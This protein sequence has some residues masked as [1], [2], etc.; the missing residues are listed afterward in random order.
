MASNTDSRT[1]SL[2]TVFRTVVTATLVYGAFFLV[3]KYALPSLVAQ[4]PTGT[5]LRS[6]GG[7]MDLTGLIR[8]VKT[9]VG[10]A[11]SLMIK[12]DERPLFQV[13][14][15]EIEINYVI[16]QEAD[17]KTATLVPIDLN[18]KI[19][20]EKV[21]HIKLTLGPAEGIDK[22]YSATRGKILRDTDITVE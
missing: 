4:S 20:S 12:N 3:T 9:Q 2:R 7:S 18:T 1:S 17:A 19:S 11:T 5:P 21:Q 13:K 15:L 8:E 16:S 22:P 6:T 10:A 14:E